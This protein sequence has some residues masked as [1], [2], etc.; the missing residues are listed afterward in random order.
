M[1]P[2]TPAR[3]PSF[4]I[5]THWLQ[6]GVTAHSATAVAALTLPRAALYP[7]LTMAG[8]QRI[9]SSVSLS[10]SLGCVHR[11][12]RSRGSLHRLILRLS[13]GAIAGARKRL[14]LATAVRAR[15]PDLSP[16][17]TA[18]FKEQLIYEQ[19]AGRTMRE[20][21]QNR[22]FK[23]A[24]QPLKIEQL[25]V[26]CQRGGCQG[27]AGRWRRRGSRLARERRTFPICHRSHGKPVHRSILV[28]PRGGAMW[29]NI[30]VLDPMFAE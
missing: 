19:S 8:L 1:P 28:I 14:S 21:L 6:D 30:I 18:L 27:E 9:V 22:P 2:L 11:H 23:C 29:S 25:R 7:S 10:W 4:D 20:H 5:L 3:S 16:Q 13:E 17:P 24:R 12:S 15:V 26:V